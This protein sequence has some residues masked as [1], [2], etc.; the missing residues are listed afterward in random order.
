M[1]SAV[2]VED[3]PLSAAKLAT[4]PVAHSHFLPPPPFPIPSSIYTAARMP[5]EDISFTLR[6]PHAPVNLLLSFWLSFLA[7]PVVGKAFFFSSRCCCCVCRRT[8]SIL[9]V[10]LIF[11]SESFSFQEYGK[12]GW[13]SFLIA[14]AIEPLRRGKKKRKR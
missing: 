12:T 5:R 11:P 3:V 2:V 7:C 6:L 13:E 1:I 8:A 4:N 9:L 10:R 14:A